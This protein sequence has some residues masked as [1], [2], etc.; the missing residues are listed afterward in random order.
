MHSLANGVSAN[1]TFLIEVPEMTTGK[2]LRFDEAS[3]AFA[4]NA[5]LSAVLHLCSSTRIQDQSDL[6]QLLL[7]LRWN[8]DITSSCNAVDAAR[9]LE[10]L[11]L[12]ITRSTAVAMSALSEA[13]SGF[14]LSGGD[15]AKWL[16]AENRA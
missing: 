4:L 14:P 9:A 16:E 6:E 2:G 13:L 10:I 8:F 7:A 3:P 5:F 15:F 12:V 11:E 1:L